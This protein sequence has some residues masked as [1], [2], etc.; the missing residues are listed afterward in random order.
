[1]LDIPPEDVPVLALITPIPQEVRIFAPLNLVQTLDPLIADA[2][3]AKP[4]STGTQAMNTDL[5]EKEASLTAFIEPLMSWNAVAHVH[6]LPASAMTSD[7]TLS[8]PLLAQCT[9]LPALQVSAAPLR[10]HY[11]GKPHQSAHAQA[12]FQI[13][14]KGHLIGAVRTQKQADEITETL[15][16]LLDRPNL[17][18]TTLQ[19][20]LKANQASIYL[21]HELLLTITPEMAESLG[22]APEWIALAWSNN[23]RQALKAEPIDIA[24]VQMAV[25]G[26]RES[27]KRFAGTASWYGPRFH[28]RLTATGE[29][30]NQNDLTVAHKTLPFGTILKVRNL[31]NN[32]TVVVRVNDRGPYVGERSLDLSKAAAQCLGSEHA[33][34]VP[35]E[36]VILQENQ[37]FDGQIALSVSEAIQIK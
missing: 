14:F 23:L 8:N 13:W 30:F 21:N 25:K 34:V 26:L 24:T 32:R 28:G 20:V 11:R 18:P 36:A 16:S 2:L 1:M 3:L 6:A 29:T 10:N 35:Y 9:D 37:P 33:G 15:R 5:V 27:K 7:A 4:T 31:E 22:Y 19:P 12:H 17:T